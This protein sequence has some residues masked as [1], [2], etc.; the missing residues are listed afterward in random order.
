MLPLPGP[1][2]TI[3][4]SVKR[5]MR[6]VGLGDVRFHDLR[7]SSASEMV[8]AGVDLYTVGAVLGHRDA[9]STKR[10]AHLNDASTRAA[11]G[12]IGRRA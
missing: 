7:H 8:N 2:I 9:K 5:A 6:R 11:I 1:K 10:Y 4:R 3:Q 12:K